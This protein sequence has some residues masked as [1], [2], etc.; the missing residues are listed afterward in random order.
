MAVKNGRPTKAEIAAIARTLKP[1]AQKALGGGIYLRLD[2]KRRVRYQLRIRM[3][4]RGSRHLGGTYASFVDADRA[5]RRLLER[6]ENGNRPAPPAELAAMPFERFAEEHWWKQHVL[7]YCDVLT[8]LDYGAV[9]ERDVLPYWTG[10]TLGSITREHGRAFQEWLTETK[11]HTRG[12]R[13]GEPAISGVDSAMA[14]FNRIMY[15]AMNEGALEVNVCARIPALGR[16]GA[17]RKPKVQEVDRR[18]IL[19]PTEVERIRLSFRGGDLWMQR[20]RAL[21]SVFAYLG[22]RPGEALGLRH[23]DWRTISGARDFMRVERALKD[24]AGYFQVGPTKNRRVRDILLWAVVAEELEQLYQAAGC[25][26]LGTLVFPGYNG[27]FCRY[28]NWRHR[29]WY[30]ALARAGISVKADADGPALP[31]DSGARQPYCM[32]H[33]CATLMLYASKPNG[34]HYTIHQVARQLGHSATMTLAVYGHVMEDDSEIAGK[35]IEQ[36]V[37]AARRAV[38]G[39]QPGDP[40]FIDDELSSIEAAALTGLSV[41]AVNARIGSGNLRAEKRNG[42]YAIKRGDLARA[43]LLTKGPNRLRG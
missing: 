41:S 38:W 1:G 4:G 32:R 2:G 39:P 8:Q 16:T 34:G 17:N 29:T 33:T 24:V 3:S 21:V 10:Y 5:R 30:E 42:R 12:A 25:P 27:E 36:V 19:A 37:R 7:K 26:A 9:L 43:G 28:D 22:L 6:K 11:K 14:I 20:C 35:T 18:E 23:S 40:D 15:H 13:K 31:T